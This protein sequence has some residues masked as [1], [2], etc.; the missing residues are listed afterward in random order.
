[1]TES[2]HVR[3]VPKGTGLLR[4]WKAIFYSLHGLASC[5]KNESAFRQEVMLAAMLIPF[6]TV[7]PLALVAK[8][9]LISS[10]F[11]VLIVELLNSAVEW[12]VDL[13]STERHLFGK[14]AK[15]MGSAA[16]FL[17]ILHLMMAWSVVLTAYWD[18]VLHWMYRLW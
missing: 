11:L 9:W 17:S 15:D 4:V 3:T 10:V 5:Y 2:N 14:R 1:M 6:A 16:V 18:Q 13:A 7:L 8:L 12:V